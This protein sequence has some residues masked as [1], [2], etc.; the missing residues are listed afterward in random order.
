M[1]SMILSWAS[2]VWGRV[3]W[4]VVGLASILAAV[5]TVRAKVR[6]TAKGEMSREIQARTLERIEE[7]K[8]IDA[9]PRPVDELHERLRDKGYL[10]E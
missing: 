6:D 1:W 3:I 2:G 8:R 7:A 5:L 9:E 10:R 4:A